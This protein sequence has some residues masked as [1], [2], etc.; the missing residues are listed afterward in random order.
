MQNQKRQLAALQA[1]NAPESDE[2]EPMKENDSDSEGTNHKHSALMCQPTGE[3]KG[4][5]GKD[6]KS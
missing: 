1:K 4:H 6:S 3:R 5:K 2:E